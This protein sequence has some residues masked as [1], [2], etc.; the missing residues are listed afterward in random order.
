MPRLS[1]ILWSWPSSPKV[2]WMVRKA[3][4]TSLGNSKSLSRTSMSTTSAPNERSAF[5]TPRPV[6]SET[7][8]SEPGPPMRTA[9]FFG[10]SFISSRLSHNFHFSLQLD[11]AVCPRRALDLVDQLKHVR[12]RR[13]AIIHDEIA[14]HLRHSRISD[15]RILQPQFIHQFSRWNGVGVLKNASCALSDWLSGAPFRLRFAQAIIDLCALG[16]VRA[17]CRRNRKVILQQRE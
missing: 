14:V 13:T 7:S 3:S 2:P 16:R 10:K 15:A 1:R 5:D 12:C 11:P 8:R 6:A 17:E 9:I 4:S